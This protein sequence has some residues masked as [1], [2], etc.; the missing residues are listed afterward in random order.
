[1]V[2][3]YCTYRERTLAWLPRR[4][5]DLAGA[6]GR[7]A[8]TLRR[9][10]VARTADFRSLPRRPTPDG[11]G[12]SGMV[13]LAE[14]EHRRSAQADDG[15]V[16]DGLGVADAVRPRGGTCDVCISNAGV[17]LGLASARRL[18]ARPLAYRRSV[19]VGDVFPLG[20]GHARRDGDGARTAD[21]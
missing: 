7:A 14:T 20:R 6:A 8:R 9:P 4:L 1:M 19:R 3:S 21:G 17:E 5:D 16:G 10:G 2:L 15:S 18:A 13:S 12:R 11:C